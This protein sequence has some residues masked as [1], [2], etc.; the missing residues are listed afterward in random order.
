M[1]IWLV[2]FRTFRFERRYV[3]IQDVWYGG[4]LG[5]RRFAQGGIAHL[6]QEA[7]IVYDTGACTC[8]EERERER[9][10][11]ESSQ[12]HLTTSQSSIDPLNGPS[13][14]SIKRI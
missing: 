10:R 9:E 13:Y 4:Q 2:R 7:T 14:P 1:I 3:L 12:T 11:E 6:E 8:V 5:G